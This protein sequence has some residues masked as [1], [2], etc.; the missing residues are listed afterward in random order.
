MPSPPPTNGNQ[1]RVPATRLRR[2]TAS[3][4]DGSRVDGISENASHG[5]LIPSRFSGRTRRYPG[6]SSVGFPPLSSFLLAGS[7]RTG[8]PR[9]PLLLAPDGPLLVTGMDWIHPEGVRR[10]SPRQQSPSLIFLE[11]PSAH[12]LGDQAPFILGHRPA[13]LEEQLIVGIL[14]HGP[15]HELNLASPLFE[16]LH[17]QHL[18]DIVPSEPVWSG[19]N[20]SVKDCAAHLLPQPVQ[21]RS[22]Q[23]RP[24]V[25]IITKNTLLLPWPPLRLMICSAN[26]RVAVR[27][28]GPVLV[29]VSKRGRRPR[30]SW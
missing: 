7:V 3:D 12:P 25:A 18:M 11:P 17:E 1:G 14:A 4:V 5:R 15:I 23:A 26:C 2:T 13:N 9:L 10:M 22:V 6:S 19:H 30:C 24:A 27:L 16:L 29:V 28:S 20:H 21:A 8:P